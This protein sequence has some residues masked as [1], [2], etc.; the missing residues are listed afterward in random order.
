MFG[1]ET[2]NANAPNRSNG[3][4]QH[5]VGG[6]FQR[7]PIIVGERG[8]ELRFENRAGFIATNRQLVSMARNAAMAGALGSGLTG[9]PVAA[10]PM[11]AITAG[12]GRGTSQNIAPSQPLTPP[13]LNVGGIT[14][15]AQPGQDARQI[16]D[17][18]LRELA[19]RQRGALYDRGT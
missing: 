9:A 11:D 14:I 17:E 12:A 3:I 10:L 13:S 4:S 18:V 19:R 15:V 2:Q 8:P 1:D 7:G 5:A 16:A 6:S